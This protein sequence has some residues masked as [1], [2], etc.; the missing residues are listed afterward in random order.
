MTNPNA[1]F[2][3]IAAL[4]L[5]A[6]PLWVSRHLPMVDLPQH[7][8]LISVLHRLDDPST[9]YP[10]L[11]EARHALTPYLGYYYLVSALNWLLPLDLANRVFL[12]AYVVGLPLSL[13]FLLRSLGRP[14][15][16][17]LLALPF[18][19]GDSFGWGFINYCAAL[20]LTLLCCGFFVRALEDVPRRRGWTAALAVCLV[21]VLL[22]H[23]QAFGFLALGLPWLL[24]TTAVP[25]DATARGLAQRLRPRV[26]ALL[27]VVPGVAL[28][29][30]WVVLRFGE[31]P[32]IQPGAPWKAWGPTFSPQNLGWKSFAQ[33]RAELFD[34]LANTLR[35]GSDRWAMYAVGAVALAGW[36]AALVRPGP[37]GTQGPVAR[38]RLLG[39]GV[40]ALALYFLL[41]FDIRGY[42]YYLNTRYAHLAAAL[43][44]ATAPATIPEWRLPLKWA[45][46]ACTLVLA[47]T[48]GRGFRA[49]SREA[50]EWE[51]L[52]AA[53]AQRPRVMGL[54]YDPG[55]RVV[56]FPVFIHSAAVLARERGGVPNFTFASTP[57]SP[58]RYRDEVPPTFPSEWRPQDVDLDTQGAW[59]DTFVVRGVHPSQVF[60]AR[61]QTELTVV[62][63][64]GRSWLVRRR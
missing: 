17:A 9:L 46:A 6:L 62:G 1:R 49:F 27:G 2:I 60:G 19:Y 12:T 8:Y 25:E 36:V 58:L 51:G 23:V 45:A 18:A 15:W 28:F 29:L 61:L 55:S 44:V 31:P 22:F 14:T 42:V 41:P 32:D 43:L 38:A 39:L 30:G 24:L 4:V 59:Y 20:P 37:T 47:F 11:F 21:T 10:Q 50:T 26:P 40:L 48:L 5:G 53:T 54:I 64:S 33:N 3:H 35:D 56:R 13:G 16:P 52:V 7:L 63:Q 34:V 57:H